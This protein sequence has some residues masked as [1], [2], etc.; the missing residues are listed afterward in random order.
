MA[1]PELLRKMKRDWYHR[2]RENFRYYIVN[3]RREWSDEEFMASGDLTVERYV[4]TDM[5]NVCRG[6]RPCDMRVLDFGCGAGRVTR[7]LGKLFG[8]VH[9]V[10]ISGEMLKLARRALADLPNIRLHETN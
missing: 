3:T 5:V 8:E 2:A 10:D 4:L 7:S 1:S 9:G 6:K